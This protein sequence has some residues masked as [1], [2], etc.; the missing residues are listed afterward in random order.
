MPNARQKGAQFEQLA[1]QFLTA[2]NLTIITT[3]Y[4]VPKVGEIDIIAV[5]ECLRI[6]GER[7]KTLIF[8]EVKARKKSQFAKACETITPAKQQKL[9]KT[10]THFLQMNENYADFDCR[11]DVL[12][13]EIDERQNFSIDWI[14]SAFWVE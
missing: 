4:N 11:F 6:T 12:A 1:C 5:H 2:Q 3:N 7:V 14:Q 13:Y 10:A 9:I 8:V